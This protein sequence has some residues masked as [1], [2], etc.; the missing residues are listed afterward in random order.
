MKKTIILLSFILA[1]GTSLFVP[2]DTMAQNGWGLKDA[3]GERSRYM[4]EPAGGG[5]ESVTSNIALLM[6]SA[7]N[8]LTIVVASIAILFTII[9]GFLMGTSGGGDRLDK[10]KKGFLWSFGGLM[11]VIFAYIITKTVISL[12]YTA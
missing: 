5:G 11:L 3:T 7:T 4:P 8:A 2:L 1:L 6:K 10:A 9:N 12:V